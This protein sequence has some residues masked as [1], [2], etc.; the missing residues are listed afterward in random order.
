MIKIAVQT[1]GPD[2]YYGV[3]GAYK[4]IKEAG[5]DAVDANIDRLAG[6]HD[7][8]NGSISPDLLSENPDIPALYAPWKKGAD[9]YGL[10]NYQAHAPFPSYVCTDKPEINDAIIRMLETTIR[11]CDYIN[12]R[13][14][15]IH[16]FFLGYDQRMTPEE[17][18]NVN[19]DR[20]SRLIPVAKKYGVKL[21]L[22]NMFTGFKGKILSACCSDIDTACRYV[23]TL[24]GIA[25]ED[26]FGFCVDTGH[27]LLL[28]LDIKE[29]LVKLGD[30]IAAFHVHDNNGNQDQHLAP[31]MGVQDWNRFVKGLKAIG[32]K[33][34]MSF[35]T[36]NLCTAVD[37]ELI[38][39]A[40]AFLAKVGRMFAR[41]AE[42]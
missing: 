18:W 10:D 31:F 42:E 8:R 5:F 17:E 41:R 38:P 9:T 22:E 29:T 39:D 15:I 28:G 40:L 23:D 11:G 37:P 7:I 12:C 34:T 1:G 13:N 26:C 25:G 36:F 30:R 14:L 4:V 27:L 21:C 2:A 3:E 19:I 35:E 20:Y 33:K 24:N 32:Y 6:Y 16:P